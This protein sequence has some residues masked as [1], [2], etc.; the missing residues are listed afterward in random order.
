MNM[1][2]KRN[3]AHQQRP[4][5]AEPYAR[6]R[7]VLMVNVGT[8]EELDVPSV[9]RYLAEFLGDPHVIQLPKLMRWMHRPLA[10]FIAW[11]RAP[12]SLEKYRLIW[13]DR[14]SPLRVILEDQA[15]ALA[16]SLPDGWKVYVGIAL[17]QAKHPGRR[18]SRSP[19]TRSTKSSFC[20]CTRT[21]AGRRRA[22]PSKRCTG[23]S[24][25]TPCTST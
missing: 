23:S 10:N 11:R 24:S 18:S 5:V 15:Q 4:Q 19:K 25:I 2:S 21:S 13:T 6:R 9:R 17:R 20:R 14:G 16:A 22:R 7:G 8:P 12:H 1:S 3:G